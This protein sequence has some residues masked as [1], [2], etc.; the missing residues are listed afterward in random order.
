MD[1][2]VRERRRAMDFVLLLLVMLLRQEGECFHLWRAVLLQARMHPVLIP[3]ACSVLYYIRFKGKAFLSPFLRDFLFY[4]PLR[5]LTIALYFKH[6]L[7]KS[8][9]DCERPLAK[10]DLARKNLLSAGTLVKIQ[11]CCVC[12]ILNYPLTDLDISRNVYW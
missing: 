2:K 1:Q 6:E 9:K 3:R 7:R 11:L 8:H 5:M 4:S 12:Y 10:I